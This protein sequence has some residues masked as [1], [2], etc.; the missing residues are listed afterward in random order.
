MAEKKM[1]GNND[2]DMNKLSGW[3][4]ALGIISVIFGF[5]LII[6]PIAGT[7]TAELLFGM[8]LLVL[9]QGSHN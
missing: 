4:L 1:F 3:F 6:G 2:T 9:G 8:L 5:V 7:V